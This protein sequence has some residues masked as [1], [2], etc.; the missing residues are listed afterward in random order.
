LFQPGPPAW[1]PSDEKTRDLYRQWLFNGV[2]MDYN[3][4]LNW[5]D[6]HPIVRESQAFQEA[7]KNAQA[8]AQATAE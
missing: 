4:D 1:Q 3:G 6:V 2:V 7:L 5:Y 8:E